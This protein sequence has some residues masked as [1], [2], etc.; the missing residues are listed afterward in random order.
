VKN[1]HCL[2]ESDHW[3]VTYHIVTFSH[4]AQSL[5]SSSANAYLLAYI[6]MSETGCVRIT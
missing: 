6:R 2:Y 1:Y 5:A 4:E 3:F